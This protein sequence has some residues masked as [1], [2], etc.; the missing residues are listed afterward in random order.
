M[1][2]KGDFF[3]PVPQF[4]LIAPFPTTKRNESQSEP[5]SRAGVE[6]K[7]IKRQ[8][9]ASIFVIGLVVSEAAPGQSPTLPST[10]QKLTGPEI[11][12]SRKTLDFENYTKDQ[13]LV[14]IADFDIASNKMGAN[15][16]TAMVRTRAIGR[17]PFA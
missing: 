4:N 8:T 14:R 3:H 10:A 13:S 5:P 11:I 16:I 9:V 12:D 6:G 15:I 2:V 1:T 17:A 7:T